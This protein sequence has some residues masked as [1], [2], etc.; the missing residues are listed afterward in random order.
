MWTWFFSQAT[1]NLCLC[2]YA[3]IMS[4]PQRYYFTMVYEDKQISSLRLRVEYLNKPQAWIQCL[5]TDIFTFNQK[6]FIS[7]EPLYISL[8]FCMFRLNQAPLEVYFL[9]VL[10]N[11]LCSGWSWYQVVAAC[12]QE[13]TKTLDTKILYKYEYVYREAK[14]QADKACSKT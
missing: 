1:Q 10:L 14:H 12:I 9:N 6:I 13:V 3:L 8:F 7:M 5:Q 4:L 11:L 2:L